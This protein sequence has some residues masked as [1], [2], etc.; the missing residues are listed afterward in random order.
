MRPGRT[1]TPEGL[2]KDVRELWDSGFF[3]DIEVD[4]TRKD[5][6]VYLRFLVRERPN[7]KTIEFEGNDEIDNDKLTEA[8]EVKANT[9]LSYPAVRRS[10]QKI[11][12]TYAEKGYFLAEVDVRGRAA[13]R[14]RGHR[15]VQDQRARAGHACGASPSS[16]T[17][18]SPTP[19]CAT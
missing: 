15:Q 13:A 17:T 7:I 2:A 6:G 19:S 1:F 5:D 12:D 11:R 16:A 9:I 10:V 3:E 8:V 4:L 18:T 14:Q